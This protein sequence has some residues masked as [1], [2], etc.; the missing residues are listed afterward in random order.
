MYTNTTARSASWLATVKLHFWKLTVEEK[1]HL[2]Y[3]KNRSLILNPR[4]NRFSYFAGSQQAYKNYVSPSI[5]KDPTHPTSVAQ[6]QKLKPVG[7]KKGMVH[8]LTH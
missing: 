1:L 6:L 3:M 5:Y 4:E 8:K 2:N 7:K